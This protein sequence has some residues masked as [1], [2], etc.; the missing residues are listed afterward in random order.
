MPSCGIIKGDF[1]L[2]LRKALLNQLRHKTP[3][4]AFDQAVN[5]KCVRNKNDRKIL[6]IQKN[7]TLN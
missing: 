3:T 6:W 5:K 4:A 1:G 7:L 2:G